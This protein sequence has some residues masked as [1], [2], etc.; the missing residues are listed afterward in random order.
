MEHTKKYILVDP[1]FARPTI[2][3]KAL[4]ALDSEIGEILNSEVSDELKA[5]Q[6]SA[7]LS[8]F[9]NYSQDQTQKINPI[10]KLES[11]VLKSV[12]HNDKYKA[13]RL[14]DRLK[15]DKTVEWDDDGQLT[16][17]QDKIPKS[18]IVDLISNTLKSKSA[19]EPPIGWEKF[20][21]S[22]AENEIPQELVRNSD[23]WSQM[24]KGRRSLTTKKKAKRARSKAWAEY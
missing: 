9:R 19:E 13:K 24:N 21:Q 16:Y 14:I 7:T 15:R 6:Y 4:S 22:L 17:H 11:Q 3:D 8:R 20:A 5:K 2:K 23:V 1:R 18:N 12:P 10:E